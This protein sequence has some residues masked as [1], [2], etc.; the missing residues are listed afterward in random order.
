[1]VGVG[2]DPD[3]LPEPEHLNRLQIPYKPGRDPLPLLLCPIVLKYVQHIFQGGA[4]IFQGV[5]VR[6][7]APLVTDLHSIS[8]FALDLTC[9]NVE[10]VCALTH[11]LCV[12]P[13]VQHIFSATSFRV[14]NLFLLTNFQKLFT[15]SNTVSIVAHIFIKRCYACS[16][17]ITITYCR[18]G[19]L[20]W[21]MGHFEKVAFS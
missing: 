15:V 14:G 18:D 10:N 7:C 2:E 9:F 20:I 3:S 4:K 11:L 21:L 12:F 6:P 16:T 1:M 5:F 19:Q 17:V 8:D 13:S